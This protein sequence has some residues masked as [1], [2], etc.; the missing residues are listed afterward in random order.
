MMT[1]V[2]GTNNVIPHQSKKGWG[3]SSVVEHLPTMCK[4]LGSILSTARKNKTK[5]TTPN[6]L[7]K[8]QPEQKTD[9]R[10]TGQGTLLI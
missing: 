2:T 6:L 1:S 9:S 4:V 10:E 8:E 3:C 7:L 5:Q